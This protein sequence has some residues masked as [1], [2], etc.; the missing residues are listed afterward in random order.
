MAEN[1]TKP[2][3][4][5]VQQFLDT[6]KPET[7][8]KDAYTILELMQNLSGEKPEMWGESIIGFGRQTSTYKSGRVVDWFKIGFSPRKQSLTLYLMGYID[9]ENPL[10]Q[11]LGKYKVGKGCLYI[12]KLSNINTE[13][14]KN[15]IISSME[16]F[17]QS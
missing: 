15:I 5:N 3:Q 7:K 13:T 17:N 9:Q 16:K 4:A 14:L 2:T 6:V 10:F 11:D 8:R 1:K 12:N